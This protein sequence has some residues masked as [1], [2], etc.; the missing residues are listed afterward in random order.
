MPYA[1]C[2]RILSGKNR[3]LRLARCLNAQACLH[4]DL[5][6]NVAT[7]IKVYV[8]D[9]KMKRV[10]YMINFM[11]MTLHCDTIHQ[12]RLDCPCVDY[13]CMTISNGQVHEYI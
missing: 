7:C 4:L 5:L 6:E 12:H 2:V 3:L 9:I 8:F 1:I 10:S 13:D 11:K